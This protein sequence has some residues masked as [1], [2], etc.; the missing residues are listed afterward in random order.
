MHK[1]D[2]MLTSCMLSPTQFC[3]KDDL[4]N[5]SEDVSLPMLNWREG[6]VIQEEMF[7]HKN[8]NSLCLS[9]CLFPK[10]AEIVR[11]DGWIE[12]CSWIA[13]KSHCGTIL[14]LLPP[15]KELKLFTANH[16]PWEEI[17]NRTLRRNGY[18]PSS[19]H[20]FPLFIGKVMALNTFDLPITS[21][22]LS[23]ENPRPPQSK[24]ESD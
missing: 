10:A 13:T 9:A 17:E 18:F 2:F 23:F 22:I 6:G 15:T 11:S 20:L 19:L 12:S 16:N 8:K 21:P 5:L 7:H 24:N 3:P 1:L 14:C 4:L